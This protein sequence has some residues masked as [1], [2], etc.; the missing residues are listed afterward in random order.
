MTGT[1]S[2]R[3]AAAF[4]VLAACTAGCDARRTPGQGQTERQSDA[5]PARSDAGSNAGALDAAADGEPCDPPSLRCGSSCVDPSSSDEHC[6]ECNRACF[7]NTE[8]VQRFCVAP[9]PANTTRC[10]QTCA[11]LRSDMRNCGDCGMICFSDQVC[12][13]GECGCAQ[14]KAPCAGVCVERLVGL[15][16]ACGDECPADVACDDGTAHASDWP[17]LGADMAR[18]GYNTGERGTPP[19]S[20]AWAISLIEDPL[21]PVMIS[22]SRVFASGETRFRGHGPLFALDLETG[23][24]LWSYD[25]GDVSSVGQP[26][27]VDCR[28]YVQQSKGVTSI[29]SRL[30]SIQADSGEAIWSRSFPSQWQTFWSP[31]VTASGVYVNA[32]TNGGLFG[33]ARSSGSPMFQNLELGQVDRW[34]AASHGTDIYTFVGGKL[35]RHAATSGAVLD[36]ISVTT[37][38]TGYSG[39]TAPVFSPEGVAYLVA[40]PRIYAFEATSRLLLWSYAANVSGMPALA[41]GR[42]LAF[43]SQL[44]TSFDAATGAVQWQSLDAEG[45]LRAPVVAAGFAYAASATTTYAVDLRDGS[46]VWQADVGGW[47]SIG[48]GRLFIAGADG[49]LHSYLLSQPPPQ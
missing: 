41:D 40:A 25:F 44:L 4:L 27:V 19:L 21:H 29:P 9:C 18:T 38:Q 13:E 49:I 8:C 28:V 2:T 23:K 12:S 46:V 33:F 7:A 36:T 48:G 31:T 37:S 10:G 17:T 35:R 1:V 5:S 32:G 24:T 11:D 3:V 39:F 45:L 42:L 14:D 16:G 30:W 20:R 26:T 6:G 34:A 43:D 22:G 15:C 47:L